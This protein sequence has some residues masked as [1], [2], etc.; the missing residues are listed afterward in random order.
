M[1]RNSQSITQFIPYYPSIEN[2]NLIEIDSII[3]NGTA[4]A[5]MEFVSDP[6]YSGGTVI[7]I[8]AIVT[9][10][11][12]PA[13]ALEAA[14]ATGTGYSAGDSVDYK[15][16]VFGTSGET[17]GSTTSATQAV[18]TPAKQVKVTW[19]H[20]P[21]S[22]Y[23]GIYRR[24]NTAGKYELIGLQSPLA[25]KFIDNAF[26]ARTDVEPPGANTAGG[27]SVLLFKTAPATLTGGSVIQEVRTGVGPGVRGGVVPG[28]K[29]RPGQRLGVFI[30]AAATNQYFS[31][32]LN[33]R[34]LLF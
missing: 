31:V 19:D 13:V 27:S 26:V 23:I 16:T 32:S 29:L 33:W 11:D 34:E 21:N 17:L 25:L 8:N 14:D 24:L 20:Q 10:A 7:P 9:P 1:A 2:K 18:G 5:W 3:M 28:T 22:A 30:D 6:A 15:I 4:A 12:T